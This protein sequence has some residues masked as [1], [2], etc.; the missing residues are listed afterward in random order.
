MCLRHTW[1]NEKQL[2]EHPAEHRHQNPRQNLCLSFPTVKIALQGRVGVKSDPLGE[3]LFV[4][5]NN[6]DCPVAQARMG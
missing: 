4:R 2:S 6:G 3:G 1:T 5:R